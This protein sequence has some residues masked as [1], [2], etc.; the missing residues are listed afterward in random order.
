MECTKLM[1]VL[2]KYAKCPLC[3]NKYI[4]NG[5]G[6]LV[7]DETTFTRTCKCGFNINIDGKDIQ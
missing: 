5:Q 3:K 1:K 6:I 2:S 4:V 7:V